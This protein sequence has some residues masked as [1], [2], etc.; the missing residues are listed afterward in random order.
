MSA[1]YIYYVYA[2]LRTDGTPYYIGKG[3]GRRAYNCHVRGHSDITPRDK[4]R[5]VFLETNL[6][7]IGAFALE[8]RMIRWYGR[9]DIGTGILW[10]FTDGGEGTTGNIQT[11][12]QKQIVR[13]YNKRLYKEGDHPFQKI[14][15]ENFYRNISSFMKEENKKR[16]KNGTHNFLDKEIYKTVAKSAS[17]QAK[18]MIGEG[19]HPFLRNK[20]NENWK[21]NQKE[22]I[23]LAHRNG[24]LGVQKKYVCC[25]Q[26]RKELSKASASR[27]RLFSD[28][29]SYLL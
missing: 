3:C 12:Y 17:I 2:Y 20:E 27:Y 1:Q 23:Q 18:R 21:T 24:K 19:T 16:M 15:K 26:T 7:E 6:S 14:D 13:E 9:K 8:R 28:I 11:D 25:I 10:N 29:V 5:I 4:S 22:S